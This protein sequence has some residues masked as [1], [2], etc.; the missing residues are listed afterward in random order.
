MNYSRLFKSDNIIFVIE[1]LKKYYTKLKN[2]L[3]K[4]NHK[5]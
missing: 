2:R 5:N 4:K 1:I 3:N